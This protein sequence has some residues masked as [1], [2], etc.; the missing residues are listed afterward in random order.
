MDSNL[1]PKIVVSAQSLCINRTR[2]ESTITEFK[3]GARA[4]LK[5]KSL[6]A[7]LFALCIAFLNLSSASADISFMEGVWTGHSTDAETTSCTKFTVHVTGQTTFSAQ[8]E[9]AEPCGSAPNT[10]SVAD[11]TVSGSDVN[12]T[13]NC[14]S[15]TGPTPCTVHLQLNSALSKMTGV[16]NCPGSPDPKIDVKLTK[17]VSVHDVS[18]SSGISN[19]TVQTSGLQWIDY[20]NDKKLD[21]Y[22]VGHNGNVLFKN[23]GKGQFVDVTAETKT[24]N[25]GKDATGASWADIDNDGDLDVAISNAS[26]R[27]TL[28]LNNNGVFQ[29]ISSHIS[30]LGI[31]GLQ[32]TDIAILRGI[33]WVD[34]NNDK[35]SDLLEVFDGAKCQLLKQTGNLMWTDVSASAGITSSGA[36]RSAI[37]A[38]FDGDG[39][40]DLYIVYFGQPNHMYRNNGNET[41]T[42][43]TQSAG[44][45]FSGKSVAAAVADY[46][47][48]QKLDLYVSN[49]AGPPVL[50]QNLG[51]FQF[52]N[53]TP[54][55]LKI[56]QKGV[57]AAFFDVDNDEDQDLIVAQLGAKNLLFENIGHG[58]FKQ[59]TGIDL[60]R[61]N[62]P[63]GIAIAD[64]N[65]DGLP[66]IAIGDSNSNTDDHNGDSLYQ[67]TGGGGNNYMTFIL[68]GTKSRRDGIG[69]QI[70]LQTGFTFQVRTITSGNGQSQ[71]SLPQEFGLGAYGKVDLIRIHWP[72]GTIQ[73]IKAENYAVNKTYTI[74]E[75]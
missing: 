15:V 8:L 58:K 27:P 30:S 21:L 20:N 52:K 26:G 16:A 72:S 12:F 45:G 50:F 29:D 53:A 28:L 74:T 46:N 38:D 70:V 48:D 7:C 39:F 61:P 41:F 35:K 4:L 69:A 5:S 33:I 43:V 23:I 47:N 54:A 36:G 3:R 71:Q 37:A 63:S 64:F 75:P 40:L 62:N 17:P 1:W 42:D 51:N 67:N 55:V 18:V 10:C 22:M 6:A 24:G 73:E 31:P 66:D 60:S 57:A 9:D 13:T 25:N 65:G 2:I 34:F 14:P 56:A 68:K 59:T 32:N 19:Q 44:V 49:S 11:G